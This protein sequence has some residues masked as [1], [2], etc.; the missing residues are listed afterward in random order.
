M[1]IGWNYRREH[2]HPDQRS[3]SIF[4]D[5]GDQ[6]NV[7]P[8]KASI[9]FYIRNITYEGIMENYAKAN[10]IAEGASLMTDTSFS[11]RILGT[12]WPRHFNKII[13]EEMYEN[14]K[15]VGLPT[16]S[17]NDE[18]LAK[19]VQKELGLKQNGLAKNISKIGNLFLINIENFNVI[20]TIFEL[21]C[22]TKKKRQP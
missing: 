1:N 4:T 12:A 8:S 14:I 17:E 7:V 20:I 13:A 18:I 19:A 2:L 10:K 9:W 5:A 6:P 16:W 15:N 11:S 22:L 21:P 3:H